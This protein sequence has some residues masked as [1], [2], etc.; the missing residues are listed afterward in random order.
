MKFHDMYFNGVERGRQRDIDKVADSIIISIKQT[1]LK[2][3]AEYGIFAR[4]LRSKKHPAYIYDFIYDSYFYLMI[5]ILFM[6][7]G[8]GD[9]LYIILLPRNN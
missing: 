3:C 1:L 9:D 8:K 4:R 5:P 6:I 2:E 7:F